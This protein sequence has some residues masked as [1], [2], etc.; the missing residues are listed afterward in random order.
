MTG[1]AGGM[2]QNQEFI[3]ESSLL[4]AVY[5]FIRSVTIACALQIRMVSERVEICQKSGCIIEPQEKQVRRLFCLSQ[6]RESLEGSDVATEADY[7]RWEERVLGG[8]QTI[9]TYISVNS[10]Q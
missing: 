3:A 6:N 8:Q 2:N 4:I 1:E 7:L 10:D 5:D 9:L